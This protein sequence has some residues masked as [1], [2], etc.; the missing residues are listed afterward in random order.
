MFQNFG[1]Y[2]FSLLFA[3]LKRVKKTA[4]QF[5]IFFKVVGTHFDDLKKMAFR[6]REESSVITCSDEMLPVHGQDR[7]MPR[8]NGESLENYRTRLAMKGIIA[9]EAGTN[10]GIRYLARAFGYD[11]VEI[12]PAPK[13]ER[14]AEA[15]VRFVGGK[16]V[17]DDEALLLQELNK[18]KP[19]RTL[20]SV[21][22]EQRYSGTHYVG[23]AYII[24]KQITISQG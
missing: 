18:I 14:W 1:E 17:L 11:S 3:P 13:P 6:V 15:T 23:S 9:Q 21:A 12:D 8:L 7:D 20:L 5:Y 24:G 19:A 16:I 2:M 10:K 4:N 22:K